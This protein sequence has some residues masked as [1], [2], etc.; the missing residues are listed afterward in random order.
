MNNWEPTFD[1][2]ELVRFVLSVASGELSKPE[3]TEIFQS[4]C[5]PNEEA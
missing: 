2:V 1:E 3:L 5:K 4:R